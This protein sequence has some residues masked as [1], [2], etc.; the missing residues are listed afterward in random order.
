M[1]GRAARQEATPEAAA[2]EVTWNGWEIPP[3]DEDRYEDSDDADYQWTG[4]Q[5]EPD[6]EKWKDDED[7]LDEH[8]RFPGENQCGGDYWLL[9]GMADAEDDLRRRKPRKRTEDESDGDEDGA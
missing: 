5:G 8:E 3:R 4:G 9:R 6:G 7:D 1:A 2:P